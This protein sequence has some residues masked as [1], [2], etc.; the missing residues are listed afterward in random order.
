MTI[1]HTF[2]YS[3]PALMSRMLTFYRSALKP[4]GYTEMINAFGGTCVGFGSDYPYLWVQQVPGGDKPYP[5][6]VAIDAPSKP[7]NPESRNVGNMLTWMTD[8]EA[9]NRF[10]RI[11]L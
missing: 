1:N 9:V 3:T 5:V 10:H 8:N 6:H 11:A 2:V 7:I 4:I